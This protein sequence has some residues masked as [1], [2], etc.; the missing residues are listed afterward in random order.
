MVS[1]TFGSSVDHVSAVTATELEYTVTALAPRSNSRLASTPDGRWSPSLTS[2]ADAKRSMAIPV[3]ERLRSKIRTAGDDPARVVTVM[4]WPM[5]PDTTASSRLLRYSTAEQ[6]EQLGLAPGF[7][8]QVHPV[9]EHAARRERVHLRFDDREAR[10]HQLRIER[11]V[12]AG[13]RGDVPSVDEHVEEA[14]PAVHRSGHRSVRHR[15]RPFHRPR[16]AEH[17]RGDDRRIVVD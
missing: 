13:R 2:V 11:G 9:A 3:S 16:R 1:I 14:V 7:V 4:N 10:L 17:C 15:A 6:P 8:G 12:L 5:S